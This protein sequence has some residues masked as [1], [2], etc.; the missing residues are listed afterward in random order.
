[1]ILCPPSP[2]EADRV[3]GPDGIRCRCNTDHEC[4]VS[5]AVFASA[6]G[7]ALTARRSHTRG[8]LARLL[9]LPLKDILTLVDVAASRLAGL[10]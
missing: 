10:R 5:I 7:P 3:V 9:T 4:L 6:V 1:M 2:A 8:V